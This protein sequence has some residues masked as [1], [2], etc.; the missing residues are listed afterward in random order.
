MKGKFITF[1]GP[2]GSGKSTQSKLLY[3]YL[4]KE[5]FDVIYLREPG[6]TSLSEKIRDILLDN[7]NKGISARA[8]LFLYLA[9]RAQIVDEII[10]PAW[11]SGKIIIC[12]R[13]MDSTL[14]YQGYGLGID[15]GFIRNTGEFITA[16]I[17]PD[18]TVLF[19][20]PAESGLK[21]SGKVKDRIENRPL[22][23]HHRVRNGYLK[24]A[25][26]SAGRIKVING[27]GAKEAIQKKIRKL[28]LDAIR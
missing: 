3:Q 5:G 21:R 24:I 23:Y 2:E 6:S 26:S 22:D 16:G 19:D 8:E 12:D 7:K 27:Q 20:L 11:A 1:E 14:A 28:V 10:R 4:K 17:K 18:L 9:A 15:T 25:R 13:F